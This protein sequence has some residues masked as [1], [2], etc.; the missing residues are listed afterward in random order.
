MGVF[1]SVLVA[2]DFSE[3]SSAALELAVA[4]AKANGADLTI[5]HVVELPALPEGM[6]PVDLITPM[7]EAASVKLGALLGAVLTRLPSARQL[8]AVGSPWEQILDSAGQVGAD[9]IVVGTHGRRGMRHALMGSVAERVVRMAP[10]P[11]LT[12]RGTSKAKEP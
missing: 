5:L 8:L 12:V 2:S 9:L 10:V 11:V 6:P 1:K 7:S 3:A 4:V